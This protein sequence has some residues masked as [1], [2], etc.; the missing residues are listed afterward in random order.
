[1]S[2]AYAQAGVDTVAGERAVALMKA[3]VLA[4]SRPEVVGDF[5]GFAGLFDASALTKFRKP[6]LATG[7][8][9]VGTKVVIA[10]KLGIH[11]TIGQD[12]VA[13]IADDIV[14]CGAEPL[15]LTDYIATGKVEPEVVADIVRGVA[16]GCK[17]A[18][19]ALLGG[20]TAEH[21]GLMAPG[22][23]DIAGAG[24]GAVEADELLG[25]HRVK[26][27]DVVIAMP[28]SGLHSNG[29]SLARHVLLSKLSLEQNVAELGRT[30]GEEMLEPTRIYSLDCLSLARELQDSLHTFSH[31]TGG[32]IAA[33]IA[34]VLPEELA[35][36]ID[37]RSWNVFPIFDIIAKLGDVTVHDMRKTFNMGIGMVAVVDAAA[38]T[39]TL[40]HLKNR[41]IAAT[42]IGQVRTRRENEIGDAEPKGGKGGAVTVR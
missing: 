20:E 11:H 2:D 19:M 8:D 28:S 33:N 42:V 34:R 27:G 25:A 41:G 18:G 15:F 5:G 17:L 35:A 37:S 3:S 13:M 31:I 4:A 29:Y 23:Y 7:T 6:L 10:Q 12:L 22:E 24:V 36:D 16:D 40:S 26:A 9:G 1:M 38:E 14:V 32:G 21:P 30:L 39:Q